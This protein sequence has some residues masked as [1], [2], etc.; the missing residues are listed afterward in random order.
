LR[1]QGSLY[2][3]LALDVEWKLK[4]LIGRTKEPPDLRLSYVF[5]KKFITPFPQT[6]GG[7]PVPM[8]IHSSASTPSHHSVPCLYHVALKIITTVYDETLET[9]KILR[10]FFMKVVV[11]QHSQ[12]DNN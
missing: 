11:T 10:G 12:E 2:I 4:G 6:R 9:F 8:L 3:N 1:G 7:E 5:P